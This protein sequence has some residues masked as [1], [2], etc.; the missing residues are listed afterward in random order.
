MRARPA[1]A[2]PR[3]RVWSLEVGPRPLARRPAPSLRPEPAPVRW[4]ELIEPP[5]PDRPDAAR[6]L[7]RWEHLRRLDAEQ[8][9]R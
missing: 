3:A 8:R 2:T 6:E 9:G 7:R 4:A 5:G 1:P